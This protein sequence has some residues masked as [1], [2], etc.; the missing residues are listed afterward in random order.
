MAGPQGM[1]AGIESLSQRDQHQVLAQLN[2]MQMAESMNTYNGL[3]ERCF[4]E[5]VTSFRTKSIDASEEQCV[6]RCVT[7]FMTFSQRIAVRFQEKQQQMGQ[8]GYGVRP[9]GQQQ[10][11][12]GKDAGY[13]KGGYGMMQAQRPMMAQPYGQQ[14]YGW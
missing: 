8:K 4:N 13:G 5:C 2:D 12:Y 6:K 1:M 3:V 14:G 7:K 9:P 11:G 10:W